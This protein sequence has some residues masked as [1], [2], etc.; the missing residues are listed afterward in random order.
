MV[1]ISAIKRAL[2]SITICSVVSLD[3]V[4]KKLDQVPQPKGAFIVE[5]HDFTIAL[6]GTRYLLADMEVEKSLGKQ[7]RK[8]PSWM[9]AMKKTMASLATNTRDTEIK[10]N[11]IVAWQNNQWIELEQQPPFVPHALHCTE[12]VL[13]A[14]AYDNPSRPTQTK[15]LI[16]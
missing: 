4:W 16:F 13:Y 6:D 7:I 11:V 8:A 9:S 14:L 15:I 12:N 5:I 1:H 3:A 10:E 2:F